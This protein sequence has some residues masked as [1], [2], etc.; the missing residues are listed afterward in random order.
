MSVVYT[1]LCFI[2]S[3]SANVTSASFKRVRLCKSVKIKN[4][5]M[6]SAIPITTPCTL[7]KRLETVITRSLH[8]PLVVNLRYVS[9]CTGG[10]RR[11][12]N[13]P[14][15]R[16]TFT[17]LKRLE[18]VTMRSLHNL[19]VVD[20]RYVGLRTRGGRRVENRPNVRFTFTFWLFMLPPKVYG[21]IIKRRK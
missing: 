5:P 7:L 10:G 4:S 9:L 20:L 15:V 6:D 3:R 11:V 2:R 16:F 17:L 8:N 12:E 19:L 21:N 14:N 13:R 18:T 1:Y